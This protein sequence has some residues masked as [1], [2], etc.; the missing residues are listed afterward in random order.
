[1]RNSTGGTNG[2]V[3]D[4]RRRHDLL[5]GL[6]PAR[7]RGRHPQ[8]R[9]AAQRRQLGEPGVSPRLQRLS[10]HHPRPP[11]P[12]PFVA[13]VGRQRHGSLRRRSRA[14][15][16]AARSARR[17]A[18]RLLHRR[19]RGGALRRP[20]RHESRRPHRAHLR[21][22]ADHAAHRK[23]SDRPAHRGVRRLP[24][25]QHRQPLPSSIA[26]SRAARSSASTGPAPRSTRASSRASGCRE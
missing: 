1:M 2:H 25:G 8:P 3:H 22:A 7:R 10:R 12:R 20:P 6:G 15:D 16:R 9:L 5:Q 24:R 11:R 14:A 13:A 19:R 23:Q 18:Y 21:R 4:P 26:T 17:L